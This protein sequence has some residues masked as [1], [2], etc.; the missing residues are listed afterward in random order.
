MSQGLDQIGQLCAEATKLDKV[1]IDNRN[2]KLTSTAVKIS[3]KEDRAGQLLEILSDKGPNFYANAYVMGNQSLMHQS[4]PGVKDSAL[5]MGVPV[6]YL[7]YD[8][9]TL[10]NKPMEFMLGEMHLKEAGCKDIRTGEIKD[11]AMS[12]VKAQAP[13]TWAGEE[14]DEKVF[15][16]QL[17]CKILYRNP[18]VTKN[19][20]QGKHCCATFTHQQARR[21]AMTMQTAQQYAENILNV[22]E[23][24]AT[25]KITEAHNTRI[26]TEG[27]PAGFPE[28]VKAKVPGFDVKAAD[29]KFLS[30]TDSG[31]VKV[32]TIATCMECVMCTVVM[33]VGNLQTIATGMMGWAQPIVQAN[34]V[35]SNVCMKY[36]KAQEA[37]SMMQQQGGHIENHMCAVFGVDEGSETKMGTEVVGTAADLSFDEQQIT[38][39]HAAHHPVLGPSEWLQ[40]M[41]VS[42]PVVGQ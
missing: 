19:F 9:P 15:S 3:S 36:R 23:R 4:V 39:T 14:W 25:P 16:T 42:S 12:V 33:E 24:G 30:A 34:A 27:F 38:F 40:R 37:Q 20:Q 28:D 29:A 21:G 2:S 5:V 35:K 18:E 13:Y 32:E 26:T 10:Q 6:P 31:K 17:P 41:Y 11:M 7:L 1:C 8:V 22:L